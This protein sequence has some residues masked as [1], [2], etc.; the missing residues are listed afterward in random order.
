MLHARCGCGQAFE[1]WTEQFPHEIRCRCGQKLIMLDTGE[2]IG[3]EAP[4]V[5]ASVASESIRGELRAAPSSMEICEPAVA[6]RLAS[7]SLPTARTLDHELLLVDR[8][9]EAQQFHLRA[10]RRTRQIVVCVIL[11]A[12]APLFFVCDTLALPLVAEF[13]VA[14]AGFAWTT[15]DEWQRFHKAEQA[16]QRK[17]W[18][19][20]VRY[21]T[22]APV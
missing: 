15:R 12:I 1:V 20:L 3:G 21:A 6:E 10:G 2:T 5:A 22:Q 17:R 16:W 11:A 7:E 18:E 13:C 19:I 4:A 9:W 14:I 8:Q